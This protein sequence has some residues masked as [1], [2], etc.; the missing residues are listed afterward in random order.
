MRRWQHRDKK[1]YA[2][3]K[4]LVVFCL[5]VNARE[6]VLSVRVCVGVCVRVRV[7]VRCVSLH[8]Y[9]CMCTCALIYFYLQVYVSQDRRIIVFVN[10][11]AR[12]GTT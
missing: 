1:I 5:C 7:C 12:S 11:H 2:P 9:L 8:M 10:V 3:L 4:E 6:P